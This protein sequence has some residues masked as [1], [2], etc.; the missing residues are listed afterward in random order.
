VYQGLECGKELPEALNGAFPLP[1]LL[2]YLDLESETA[3]QRLEGRGEYEIF[4]TAGFQAQVRQ[5]YK[6]LLP[7][8]RKAGVRVLEL[9]GKRPPEDLSAE[10]WRAVGEMPIMKAK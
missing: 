2:V 10:I 6:A 4:E 9:D 3:M 8:Y 1:E 7:H 5:A